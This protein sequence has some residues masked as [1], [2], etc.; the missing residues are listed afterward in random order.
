MKVISDNYDDE[1]N[2]IMIDAKKKQQS[3]FSLRSQYEFSGFDLT[4]SH[5]SDQ[6]VHT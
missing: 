4:L 3:F 5:S 6:S 2:M 1:W